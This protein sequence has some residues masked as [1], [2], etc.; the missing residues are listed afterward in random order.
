MKNIRFKRVKSAPV[1]A[2][3][4]LYRD[5]GW[6]KES[7]R[8]RRVIPAMIKGSDCFVIAETKEGGIVGMGRVISDGVSDGYIQDVVIRRDFQGRGVGREIVTRLIR[9]CK[10]RG[11][12]WTG[13]V[14]CPRTR[15][16]YKSLGFGELENHVAMRQM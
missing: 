15:D 6:W 8:A 1:K 10:K 13:L 9:H 4:A 12:E 7:R 3:V 14:A 5:A 16:F 11:L 2:V